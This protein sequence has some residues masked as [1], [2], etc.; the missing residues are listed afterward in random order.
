[1]FRIEK[2]YRWRTIIRVICLLLSI[3]SAIVILIGPGFCITITNISFYENICRNFSVS[4]WSFSVAAPYLQI[5]V[6]FLT[7]T[8]SIMNIIE[9]SS[10]TTIKLRKNLIT[11]CSCIFTYSYAFT[12]EIII[13]TNLIQAYYIDNTFSFS[14]K[15]YGY[16][17][18][19]ICFILAT[20]LSIIDYILFKKQCI[21]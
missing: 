3:I 16:L 8:F 21:H 13:Y 17:G 12:I 19:G 9:I 10:E 11:I 15:I 6:I 7:L 5:S 1:M 2:K 20:I 18:A 14:I 4:D